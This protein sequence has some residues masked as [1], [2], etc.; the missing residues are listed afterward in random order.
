[1]ARAAVR[2]RAHRG[3]RFDRRGYDARRLGDEFAARLQLRS[4]P[5][6]VIDGWVA[7]VDEAMRPSTIGVWLSRG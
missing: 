3:R 2:G 5:R 7:V 6:G 1:M 4:D